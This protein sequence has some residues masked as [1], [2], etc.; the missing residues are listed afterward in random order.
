MNIQ[1][2]LQNQI[3]YRFI[4]KWC[5]RNRG[6]LFVQSVLRLSPRALETNNHCKQKIDMQ[7]HLMEAINEV[8]L[9]WLEYFG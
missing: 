9:F 8:L 7:V 1:S 5:L 6:I 4:S 2:K 3:L